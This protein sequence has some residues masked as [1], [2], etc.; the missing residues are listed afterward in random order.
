MCQFSA[1]RN[2]LGIFCVMIIAITLPVTS[3]CPVTVLQ[4]TLNVRGHSLEPISPSLYGRADSGRSWNK[5]VLRILGGKG[6]RIPK[7]CVQAKPKTD[8]SDGELMGFG[9][10]HSSNGHLAKEGGQLSD[11]YLSRPKGQYYDD[12]VLYRR[13]VLPNRNPVADPQVRAGITAVAIDSHLTIFQKFW[14]CVV[15]A[16]RK[17]ID[18]IKP[19]KTVLDDKPSTSLASNFI[20]YYKDKEQGIDDT[21]MQISQQLAMQL[22]LRAVC[23]PPECDNTMI[24]H[25]P[26][27]EWSL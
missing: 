10:T 11:F 15:Y 9:F 22:R 13:P 25:K 6:V 18:I 7:T 26:L 4:S 17:Q 19:Q 3:A 20:A 8:P 14:K 2:C 1:F 12:L 16:D 5:S 27:P 24:N 23:L 21:V